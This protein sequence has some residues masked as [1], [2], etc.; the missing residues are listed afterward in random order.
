MS[1][2]KDNLESYGRLCLDF[3]KHARCRMDRR[4]FSELE[5]AYVMRHGQLFRRTG[6]CFYFLA[7][8]DVPL[9][10]RKLPWVQRLVGL[11]VLTS[12]EQAAII[13]LYKNQKALRDIKKKSK[14][15]SNRNR[16]A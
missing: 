7:A 12:P 14:F 13:T 11:T 9:A 2:E 4:N 1:V 16:A 15:R 6:I 8:R 5:V 10:D 3:T